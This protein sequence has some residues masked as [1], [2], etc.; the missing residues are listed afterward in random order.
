[1][2]D[3]F[4]AEERSDRFGSVML[5][6]ALLST[7]WEKLGFVQRFYLQP[8]PYAEDLRLA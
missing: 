3:P 8:L 7:G 2:A 4:L 5:I 1:L 6:D